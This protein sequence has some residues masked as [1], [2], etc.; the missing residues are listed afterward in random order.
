MASKIAELITVL[1]LKNDQYLREIAKSEARTKRFSKAT[2]AAFVKAAAGGAAFG[3]GVGAAFAKLGRET[4]DYGE[5]LSQLETRLGISA[6]AL[7]ELEFVAKQNGV[8]FN[9]LTLGIQRMTR[10][11]SESAAGFGE[12]KNSLEELG[13]DAVKLNQLAPEDQFASI[14]EALSQVEGQSNKVRLAFKL[15][16]AEGVSVLQTMENGAKGINDYREVA[17][18]M[19]LTINSVQAKQL[20]AM[21]QKLG[22][23]R[24]AVQGAGRILIL[25]LL[26]ALENTI[27]G[28][29]E[30]VVDSGILTGAINV[31]SASFKL[32][33]LPVIV[34]K[35]LLE[36]VLEFIKGIG[37]ALIKVFEKDFKGAIDK[38]KEGASKGSE[39]LKE[40]VT[41]TLKLFEDAGKDAAANAD[42]TADDIAKP[43]VLGA[44]KIKKAVVEDLPEGIGKL[45]EY[46]EQVKKSI[47]TGYEEFAN[48]SKILKLLLEEDLLTVEEYERAV[49]KLRE[50]FTEQGKEG[51][52]AQDDIKEAAEATK[53]ELRGQFENVLEGGKFSFQSL[54]DFAIKQ[55]T[56]IAAQNVLNDIFGS[57]SGGSGGGGFLGSIIGGLFGGGKANGGAVEAGKIYKVG[58]RGE[59]LFRPSTSGTIIPNS[60][61]SGGGGGNVFVT[62][63][64]SP[65]TNAQVTSRETSTGDTDILIKVEDFMNDSLANGKLSRT[66]L[67]NFV[68]ERKLS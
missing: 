67:N 41:S 14:A 2:K 27:E 46:A 34:I 60:R 18:K 7:S 29:K 52:K 6:G 57:S 58:E 11:I 28:V 32:L 59:E 3:L 15:F 47:M 33:A 31:L 38:L 10:R 23:T 9:Q 56:R 21:N 62:V 43:I 24:G 1:G 65:N 61:A 8:E 5:K 37:G 35:N 64:N 19:G 20:A 45:G 16:D 25:N 66:L 40:I 39:D 17:R 55:L 63:V 26:P 36:A 4:L 48:Q 51:K 13:L 53:E 54:A 42:S 12:A 30:F 49:R 44:E 22:E 50:E 68:T